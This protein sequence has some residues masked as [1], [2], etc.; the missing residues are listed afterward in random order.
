MEA[1]SRQLGLLPRGLR[2]E[3][4]EQ[5]IRKPNMNTKDLIRLGVP[6]GE[7]TRRGMEFIA[8]YILKGLDKAKLAEDVEAVVRDPALLRGRRI[9][10]RIRQGA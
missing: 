9:A 7:A 5:N 8:R 2:E 6:P 4:G 3:C 1:G 10:R